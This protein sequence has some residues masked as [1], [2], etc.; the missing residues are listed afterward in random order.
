LRTFAFFTFW[1][2]LFLALALAIGLTVLIL[3][4]PTHDTWMGFRSNDPHARDHGMTMKPVGLVA[5]RLA[6]MSMWHPQQDNS[7]VCSRCGEK[8]GLYPSGQDALRHNYRLPII[9]L[10]CAIN[11][12]SVDDDPPDIE[13]AASVDQIVAEIRESK[14]RRDSK[15]PRESG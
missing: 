4:G 14:P 7:R 11:E 13:P 6:D 15:K 12:Y 5:N 1:V 2:G 3:T 8:V 10:P 9:C